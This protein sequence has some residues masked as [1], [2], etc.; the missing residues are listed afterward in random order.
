MKK[1]PKLLSTIRSGNISQ[2]KV[3][4][5]TY[6]KPWLPVLKLLYEQGFIQNYYASILKNKIYIFFRYFENKSVIKSLRIFSKSSRP[7]YIKNKNIWRFSKNSG[8][9]VIST[10][11]GILSHED[12]LK[13]GVGGKLLFFIS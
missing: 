6:Y 12:C 13:L 10:K 3:L 5:V 8:S 11:F 2:L 7:L 1:L 4:T 9:L